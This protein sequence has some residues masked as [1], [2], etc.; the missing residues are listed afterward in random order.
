[1]TRIVGIAERL[2]WVP[3]IARWHWEEWG[4]HDRDGSLQSWMAALA[5]RTRADGI[6]T[7]FVAVEGN[8]PIG[9]AC[10]VEHD[11]ATR[12]DLH[13]WLAGVFVVP[14]QRG[15]GVG[16]ALV[17]HGA[18]RA[19]A[20]GVSSLF[21]YTNGAEPVYAKLGWRVRERAF[22][23]GRTVTIMERALSPAPADTGERIRG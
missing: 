5:Q 2:D 20:L 4:H 7:T 6:P 3:T 14:E 12:P 13:P 8:L 17:N 10:L 1:V 21:L 18:A 9:S 16:S 11:M 15:R 22:Y 19:A 23:E